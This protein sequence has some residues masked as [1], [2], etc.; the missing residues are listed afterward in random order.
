[1]N[2]SQQPS[3]VDQAEVPDYARLTRL[4]WDQEKPFWQ[5]A[6]ARSQKDS[7]VFSITSGS[8][9]RRMDDQRRLTAARAETAPLAAERH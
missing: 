5:T 9:K 3:S 4:W 1:M 8:S 2:T 6:D 7:P